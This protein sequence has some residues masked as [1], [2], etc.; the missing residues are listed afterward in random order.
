M[1]DYLFGGGFFLRGGRQPPAKALVFFHKLFGPALGVHKPLLPCIKG[2]RGAGDIKSDQGE[3]FA[4]NLCFVLRADCGGGDDLKPVGYVLKNHFP[5][6]GMNIFFHSPSKV[7]RR[8]LG[9]QTKKRPQKSARPR[10]P[11]SGMGG[12][13][14]APAL[15]EAGKGR[16]PAVFPRRAI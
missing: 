11:A 16:E 6:G 2:V 13:L 1:T 10:R 12:A 8:G 7:A 4:L 15:P 5:A 3:G 9:C 14:K